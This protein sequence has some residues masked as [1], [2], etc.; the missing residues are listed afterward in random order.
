MKKVTPKDC[1]LVEQMD[2][3]LALKKEL[4]KVVKRVIQTVE[5][6]V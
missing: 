3:N 5:K 6:W 1:Y 4:L 2:T